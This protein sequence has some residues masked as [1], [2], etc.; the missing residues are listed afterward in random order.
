MKLTRD[1][2]IWLLKN[3]TQFGEYVLTPSEELWKFDYEDDPE[4][5]E[6]FVEKKLLSTAT[7]AV[8]Q[9]T[10]DAW[11][12]LRERLHK[13]GYDGIELWRE[14]RYGFLIHFNTDDECA[15][16]Y[17]TGLRKKRSYKDFKKQRNWLK[18]RAFQ[19]EIWVGKTALETGEILS[20]WR[21]RKENEEWQ[22]RKEWINELGERLNTLQ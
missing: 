9:E 3:S 18:G 15:L 11:L 12:E 22:K 10:M 21:E 5:Y 6:P 2:V 1:R 8:P 17:V 20:P 13:T 7:E 16:A 4:N 14:C 19:P